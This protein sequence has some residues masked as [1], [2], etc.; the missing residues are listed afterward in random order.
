MAAIFSANSQLPMTFRYGSNAS[1]S[2]GIGRRARLRAWLGLTQCRFK[3]CL[4]HL[5]TKGLT[6]NNA[7]G[8]FRF[9]N[10]FGENLGKALGSNRGDVAL[11]EG[12][13][14]WR[15]SN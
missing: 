15:L 1:R 7:V 10:P 5:V 12:G 11:P 9:P 4:R 2:G 13:N 3:S 8:P 14:P 6:A